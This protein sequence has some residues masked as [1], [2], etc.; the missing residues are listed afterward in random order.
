[1][2]SFLTTSQ[3]LTRFED[4]TGFNATGIFSGFKTEVFEL[5]IGNAFDI[6]YNLRYWIIIAFVMGALITFS[7]RAFNFYRH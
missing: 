2:P 1:M 6:L 7:Q 3:A 4:T 5:F